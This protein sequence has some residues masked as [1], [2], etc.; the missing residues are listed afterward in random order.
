MCAYVRYAPDNVRVQYM[1]FERK[2]LVVWTT[3]SN[4]EPKVGGHTDMD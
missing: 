3:E 2:A 4:W 1:L